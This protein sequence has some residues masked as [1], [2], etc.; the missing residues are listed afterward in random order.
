MSKECNKCHFYELANMGFVERKPV[1]EVNDMLS[2]NPAYSTTVMSTKS[3]SD[4]I[5]CLQLLSKTFTCTLHFSFFN[6]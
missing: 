4:I 2:I 5:F 6:R 3:D 1:F